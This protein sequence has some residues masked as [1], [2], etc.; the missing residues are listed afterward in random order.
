MTLLEIVKNKATHFDYYRSG[1]LWYKTE[2]GFEYPVPINDIGNGVFLAKDKA[3]LHMRY[4]RK[5]LATIESA[6]AEQ[7]TE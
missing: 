2:G 7:L 4:I 6:K 3:I 1:E 5:Y